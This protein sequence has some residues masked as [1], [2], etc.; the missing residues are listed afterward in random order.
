MKKL[1]VLILCLAGLTTNMVGCAHRGIISGKHAVQ[2]TD[3]TST[4]MQETDV[5][6]T[7]KTL[8]QACEEWLGGGV[9]PDQEIAV[10]SNQ[11]TLLQKGVKESN[12][13][14]Y[15]GEGGGGVGMFMEYL[16]KPV[17]YPFQVERTVFRD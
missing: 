14:T 4:V 17:L 3:A 16:K 13:M 1:V 10:V 12:G 11:P 15:K 9:T 8:A 2:S 7:N 5:Q 6:N